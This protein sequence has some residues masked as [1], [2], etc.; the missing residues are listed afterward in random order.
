MS[1][2]Y[3]IFITALFCAF[4]FGFGIAHFILPD[5]EFSE[6]E[7][8][9]LAQFKA[10]TWKTVRSGQFMEDFEKYFNQQFP[11]RDQ[12]VQLK[13]YSERTLGKQENNKVYFGADGGQTLFAHFT[14]LSRE[15]L[16]ARVG[17]VNKLGGNL[18][19]PVYFSLVPDKS[20]T[21]PELLPANAPNVDD[22]STIGMVRELCGDLLPD[23]SQPWSELPPDGAVYH[24]TY[25]D[26]RD[27]LSGTEDSFYRTDHHWTTWGAYQ[28]FVKLMEG[29]GMGAEH[30][31]EWLD[32]KVAEDFYGTTYS[33]SGAGWVKPDSIYRVIPEGGAKGNVTVTRYPEG[34]PIEGGLYY[35]EKLAVKDKYA[36]F[37][38]GNQPLC[39]VRNPDAANGKLL[40]IRDSYA[41]SLAPF[42]AEEFQEVH[43][44]DL[45]YNNTSLKKY[46]ADNQ[47]D[48]VLVLYSANNFN[49]D[50]N[51]F[52]L[53]L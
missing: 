36:Y 47:I 34:E 38:G 16:A 3:S 24:V 41:D 20:Y 40:V 53:G 1:R 48:Q 31:E 33:A 39:I 13:A 51:L 26:L 50:Q 22:G 43:L 8:T 18:D 27:A 15:E 23:K 4:I 32:I 37:L 5:R 2:K 17:F 19:V 25:I 30:D 45:R 7:N 9:Y 35:P 42:L 29:M 46:V 49:T 12:W 10:P 6:Q 11:L 52:K 14:K 28:G 21:Y 44:F